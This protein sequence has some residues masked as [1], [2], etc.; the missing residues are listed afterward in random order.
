MNL[1]IQILKDVFTLH[2]RNRLMEIDDHISLAWLFFTPQGRRY[3]SQYNFPSLDRFRQLRQHTSS[4]KIFV[5][6]GDIE[7]KADYPNIGLVGSTKAVVSV[8]D[9][10]KVYR[11]ILMHGAKA[12]II[13]SNYTVI[14]LANMG[15]CEVDIEK[16]DTVLVLQ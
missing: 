7:I 9:N 13:A 10:S 8:T 3:C 16:D 14:L 1:M 5:D 4:L 2:N 15:P 6:A 11:V 12:R